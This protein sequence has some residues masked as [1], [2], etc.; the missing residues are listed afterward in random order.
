MKFGTLASL[1]TVILFCALAIPVRLVAQ[2]TSSGIIT[3]DA[4]GASATA[5][6][7][8]GT[9]SRFIN[10]AGVIMGNYANATSVNHGFLRNP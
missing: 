8:N 5:G 2:N 7:G 1:S 9:F 4:P 3:C 10:V 6:S